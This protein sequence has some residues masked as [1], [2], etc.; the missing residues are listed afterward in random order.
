VISTEDRWVVSDKAQKIGAAALIGLATIL[1]YRNSVEAP[2]VF[3]DGPAILENGSIRKLWPIAGAFVPP[4]GTTVSGRPI[5]NLTLAINYAMSGTQPLGYHLFNVGIHILCG[6]TLFAIIHRTLSKNSLRDRFGRD[7]VFLAAGI[8]LIWVLH[9][10]QT[11]AVTYV[12]QRVESLMALFYL[13]TIYCFIRSTETTPSIWWKVCTVIACL[14]GMATKEV[15]VTAP[16]LVL[17]YD[18]TFVSGSFRR[19]WQLNRKLYLWLAATWLPLAFLLMGTGGSRFGSAG[20]GIISPGSYWL[21]QIYAVSRYARLSFWPSGLVFD[22]GPFLIREPAKI[23]MSALFDIL[24]GLLTIIAVRRRY[25]VG[26]LGI[27][28][29]MILAPTCVVPVATQ[30]ISEHRMYLA[31]APIICAFALGLYALAGRKSFLVVG[32][33]ASVLGVA[34]HDRNYVYGTEQ[35]L[36]SDTVTKQPGN[37]RAHCSLG[38]ALTKV[39]GQMPQAIDEFKEA[40]RIHPN[41]ADAHNDLGVALMATPGELNEAIQEFK[42]AIQSRPGFAEAHNDLG[43]ALAK[44]DRFPEAVAQYEEALSMMPGYAEARYNFANAL[45]ALGSIDR[46][47]EQFRQAILV[48]PDFVEAHNNLGLALSKIPGRAGD[49]EREF[50][51]TLRLNPDVAEAH[52]NLGNVLSSIPGRL[53]DAVVQ[54]EEAIRLR[55]EYAD[56]HFY[57]ANAFTAAGRIPDAIQQYGKTLEIQPDLAEAS[58]NLGMLLCRTGHPQDGLVCIEAAL[59]AQPGFVPAHFARAAALLQMGKRDDAV[60]ELEIVLH[61]R[62]QD[63]EARRMLEMIHSA[64]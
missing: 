58:T 26:F 9:P 55:P 53:D 18:S 7:A 3:D 34:A 2:F 49:A 64:R 10:L 61:L 8:A 14:L 38:L 17:L 21:T 47:V 33:V 42:E 40:I 22:Y 57:L 63:A 28:F 54:Y 31:L 43:L 51:E 11:E 30:T 19:A 6:L 62:P 23:L 32:L 15:M 39:P 37:A 45:S 5:A 4:P 44:A 27:W 52:V 59:Q 50:E 24:L 1:T 35:R 25:P 46:A 20:F 41:Y 60:A 12:V 13:L 16:L 48:R 29:F 56:A 36:W